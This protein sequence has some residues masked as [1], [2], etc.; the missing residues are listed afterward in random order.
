MAIL[1]TTDIVDS[2]IMLK[3]RLKHNMV[4]DNYYIQNLQYKRD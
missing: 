1:N 4:G 3:A 2:S